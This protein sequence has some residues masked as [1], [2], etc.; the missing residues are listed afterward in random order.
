MV[1]VLVCQSQRL[2]EAFVLSRA[3]VL[4][5]GSAIVGETVGAVTECPVTT[6]GAPIPI[7]VVEVLDLAGIRRCFMFPGGSHIVVVVVV[8]VVVGTILFTILPILGGLET[9]FDLVI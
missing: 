7:L 1:V 4:G 2:V 8:V 6:G 9:L 3:F 5:Y